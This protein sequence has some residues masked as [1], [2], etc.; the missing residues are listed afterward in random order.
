MKAHWDGLAER[1][2]TGSSELGILCRSRSRLGAVFGVGG[3]HPVR[4]SGLA[5]AEVRR[6]LLQVNPWPTVPSDT[7]H[8]VAELLGVP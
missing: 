2:G 1:P 8:V 3:L 5:D 6:D 7:D 4:Q